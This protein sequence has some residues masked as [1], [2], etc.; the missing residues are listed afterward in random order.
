MSQKGSQLMKSEVMR[1]K[2]ARKN[3]KP[4]IDVERLAAHHR[5]SIH[6]EFEFKVRGAG[7]G[8]CFVGALEAAMSRVSIY[9]RKRI[10]LCG[11]VG[12]IQQRCSSNM[13]SNLE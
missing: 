6:R 2:S 11:P 7:A 10:R 9:E 8:C 4:I 1:R 3:I 5:H 12:P 13:E